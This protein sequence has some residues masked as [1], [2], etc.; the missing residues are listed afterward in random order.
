MGWRNYKIVSRAANTS[1]LKVWSYMVLPSRLHALKFNASLIWS[2]Q[3][4]FDLRDSTNT[5]L[6]KHRFAVSCPF[7]SNLF[8]LRNTVQTQALIYTRIHSPLWT[9]TRTPYPYEHLRKTEP[10]DRVLRLTKSPRAPRYRRECRLPLK[11]Y[12]AFMRH[13][14]VKP[15]VWTLVGWGYNHPPNHPTTGWFSVWIQSDFICSILFNFIAWKKE[16]TLTKRIGWMQDS[17]KT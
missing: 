6:E 7:E 3:G 9:H 12:S 15:G 14:D 5:E 11:E 2:F 4:I 1:K 17:Y 8:F 10:T 13:T 16:M